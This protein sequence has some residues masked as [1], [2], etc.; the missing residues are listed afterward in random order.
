M[1]LLKANL[2]S[3]YT[4]Q[5]FKRIKAICCF[6]VEEQGRARVHPMDD[7]MLRA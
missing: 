3:F 2:N 6:S 1:W 7:R 5:T 4:Q